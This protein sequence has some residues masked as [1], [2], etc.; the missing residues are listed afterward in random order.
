MSSDTDRFI[1]AVGLALRKRDREKGRESPLA[2]LPETPSLFMST[3]LPAS[4]N[5]PPASKSNTKNLEKSPNIPP[6]LGSPPKRSLSTDRD[7][8]GAPAINDE[9]MSGVHAGDGGVVR[10]K[11]RLASMFQE[12]DE[13]TPQQVVGGSCLKLN[14]SNGDRRANLDVVVL[15]DDSDDS[16]IDLTGPRPEPVL[17]QVRTTA[18]SNGSRGR[19]PT[20]GGEET[21]VKMVAYT[22][23]ER[24]GLSD[25]SAPG[26]S[27]KESKKCKG[28]LRS[29]QGQPSP[30]RKKKEKEKRDARYRSAPSKAALDRLER[31]RGHRLFLVAKTNPD[32]KIQ[33]AVMGSNGNIYNCVINLEP[34]CNCPDFTKRKD[35]SQQGPCKHLIFIFM[36]VLKLDCEDPRWWQKRLVQ[37][38]LDGLINIAQQTHNPEAGVLADEA[39]RTEYKKA[40]SGKKKNARRPLEGECTICYE[41]LVQNDG[42]LRPENV[43]TFCKKCGNNFHSACL[44]NWFR[45]QSRRTCP[46]CRADMGA[47]G[48]TGGGSE[49]EYLNLAQHS[50]AH[51]QEL[52]LEQRYADSHMYI[53]NRRGRWRRGTPRRRGA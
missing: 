15:D 3:S 22:G 7:G 17:Q 18:R 43:I 39:V 32:G 11:R 13:V 44:E 14:T 12:E 27:K 40:V 16:C 28:D 1:Q 8:G 35:T 41:D 33:C 45:A 2:L 53:G 20:M 21:H 47:E 51:E 30:K 5:T 34:H 9:A 36:R 38:E 31:S 24:G 25:R 46:L 49:R 52:T 50:S 4:Q 29:D 42:N 10:P 23:E 6:L 26:S 37:S 19:P 48:A